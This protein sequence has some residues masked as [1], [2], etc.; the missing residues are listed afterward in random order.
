MDLIQLLQHSFERAVLDHAP[1]EREKKILKVIALVNL[2]FKVTIN[3]TILELVPVKKK[4]NYSNLCLCCL[5]A[6]RVST[7]RQS[8]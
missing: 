7:R 2:L 1:G 3:V 4:K 5:M 8:T 6:E